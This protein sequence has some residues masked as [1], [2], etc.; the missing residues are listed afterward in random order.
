MSTGTRRQRTSG[1]KT[2]RTRT[3]TRFVLRR[4][5]FSLSYSVSNNYASYCRSG[6]RLTSVAHPAVS[7]CRQDE[8][9]D[10]KEAEAQ[11]EQERAALVK[12]ELTSLLLEVTAEVFQDIA[13]EVLHEEIKR[14][15]SEAAIAAEKERAAAVRRE[16][17]R[18]A[19]R[20]KGVV[21]L[22]APGRP[23]FDVTT[24]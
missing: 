22:G 9:V 12:R 4:H 15:E 20:Q 3:K 16:A 1:R 10:D 13:S 8:D 5:T 19:E 6:P 17:E 24:D 18:E 23:V 14:S 7:V 11:R 21:L 2:N